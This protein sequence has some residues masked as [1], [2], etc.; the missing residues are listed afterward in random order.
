MHGL[1]ARS[2]EAS[3]TH[4]AV[5]CAVFFAVLAIAPPALA[6]VTVNPENPVV[7]DTVNATGGYGECPGGPPEYNFRFL[8]HNSDGSQT[9]TASGPGTPD[10]SGASTGVHYSH[11]VSQAAESPAYYTVEEDAHCISGD[12]HHFDSSGHFE[13][14]A[15]LGGSI[16]VSPD[17]AVVNQTARLS[18][19]ATN[20]NPG[21]TFAWDLNND[22]NFTDSTEREVDT[23]F[24]TVGSHDVSVQIS[25]N[26]EGQYELTHTTT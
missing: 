25:D 5:V 16:S 6:V 1:R 20:G 4:V 19:A 11:D 10:S 23:T 24:T 13:V 12:S 22:G 7:G 17:P 9:V 26:K 2:R 8:L 21:Y 14:H 3:S 15:G 18:A